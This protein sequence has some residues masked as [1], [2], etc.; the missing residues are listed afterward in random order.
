MYS[1]NLNLTPKIPCIFEA[2]VSKSPVL[3][4]QDGFDA[5]G[6]AIA[7]D[8]SLFVIFGIISYH[9]EAIAGRAGWAIA[10]NTG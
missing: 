8:W 10:C 5:T 3:V 4:K 1:S 9:V 7:I 6:T 2:M